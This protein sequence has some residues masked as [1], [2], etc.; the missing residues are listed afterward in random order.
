[1]VKG[2]GLCVKL[3]HPHYPK[4]EKKFLFLLEL[5][6]INILKKNLRD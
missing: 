3:I 5:E 4:R 6:F 2:S 1:M